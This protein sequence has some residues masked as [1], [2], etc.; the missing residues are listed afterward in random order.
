MHNSKSFQPQRS[1][2]TQRK[3]GSTAKILTTE[4]TK[5]NRANATEEADIVHEN[6]V[7][8]LCVTLRPLWFKVLK[9]SSRDKKTN[10]RE[11][12]VSER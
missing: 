11:Q 5:V 4:D 10:H 1:L 3:A 12:R 8:F 6:S 7:A 2:S 9:N